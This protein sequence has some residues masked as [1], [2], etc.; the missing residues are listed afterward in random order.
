LHIIIIGR[1]ILLTW[2]IISVGLSECSESIPFDFQVVIEYLNNNKMYLHCTLY[3]LAII[4]NTL[5]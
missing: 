4:N 2:N 5:R 3:Q 1:I